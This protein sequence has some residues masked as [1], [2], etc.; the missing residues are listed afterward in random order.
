MIVD[1]G[2]RLKAL[3]QQD[4]LYLSEGVNLLWQNNKINQQ[5]S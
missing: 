4:L 3:N 1:R 5:N 2:N